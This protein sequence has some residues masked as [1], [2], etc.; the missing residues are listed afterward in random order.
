MKYMIT[1]SHLKIQRWFESR[2][3]K[4][5]LKCF[6]SVKPEDIHIQAS[7]QRPRLPIELQNDHNFLSILQACEVFP[8]YENLYPNI[9]ANVLKGP[10]H[11]MT[12]PGFKLFND[13]MCKEY[14]NLFKLTIASVY[15]FDLGN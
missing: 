5:Y 11:Y 12:T 10:S 4:E 9:A 2:S 1:A 7:S 15:Q 8:N 6:K 14:H 3:S 13:M